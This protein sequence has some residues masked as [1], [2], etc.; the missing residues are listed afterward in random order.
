MA[1]LRVAIVAPSTRLPGGQ[2]VQAS[3]LLRAWQGDA[4]VEAWLLSIDSRQA[5]RVPAR[6]KYARQVVAT[7]LYMSRLAGEILRADLVH[8]FGAAYRAF[9]LA[10]LPALVCGRLCRRPIVFHYHNGEG[11]DHLRRS[12]VA[13]VAIARAT[14]IVVPS[15]YLVDV[16]ERFGLRAT[17]IANIVP[18]D[19]FTFRHRGAI[20]PRL[21]STRN[22]H[23]IYNV[24]CTL[25]AFRIVQDAAPQ[26]TLTIAGDGPKRPVLERLSRLLGL[27]NVRFV[28]RVDHAAMPALYAAHDIYIQTPDVDNNP[29]SILEAF[30]TG[31][32]VVSTA[33]GG[34]PTMVRAG[35]E[36]LLAPAN[37]DRAIS[38]HVLRLLEDPALVARLSAAGRLACSRYSWSAVRERWLAV[39]Q[40]AIAAHRRDADRAVG[41][42]R[43]GITVPLGVGGGSP[44]QRSGGS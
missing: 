37:Y 43:S 22:L 1:R 11:P 33:V 20:A 31:L 44:V 2:A 30:A 35:E 42:P 13:R 36:G 16:F 4:A 26:A 32:P 40:E 15:E 24:A 25:R 39:Y 9:L 12:A 6:L 14:R 8:V 7:N 19:E 27:Q 28:G 29:N 41:L 3:R 23:E 18:C 21:L 38:A 5:L 10:P 34:V 17:A